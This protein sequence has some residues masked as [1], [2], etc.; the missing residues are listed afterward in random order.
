MAALELYTYF[1]SSAAYRVRI[2]LNLKRLAYQPRFVHLAKGE[3]R[4]PE[5]REINPQGLV[6][7]LVDKGMVFTQSLAI[8]EYLNEKYPEPPLLPRRRDERAYV[9]ALAQILACDI[10]PLNNLRV[11][12]Y[13]ADVLG[14][15]EPARTAWIR[16]W[17]EE[18]FEA[19]EEQLTR[20][21]SG[22]RFCFGDAP[23]LA[24]ICLV[25]Q[26]FNA[27]RFGCDLSGFPKIRAIDE[28]CLALAAFR[29]AAPEQQADAS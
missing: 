4:R 29:D 19:F 24:D 27:R 8:I 2:A 11:T 21:D 25:P 28:N 3:Q 16:H 15:D 14:Q 5:Y 10:H 22:G 20:H 1:R 7:T 18:G 9:R 17:I 13:L 23:T 6:P 26:V 12:R